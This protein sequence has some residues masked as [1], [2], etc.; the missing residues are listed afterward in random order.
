MDVEILI[1]AALVLFALFRKGGSK[2]IQV[3]LVDPTGKRIMV[4]VDSNNPP[5]GWNGI[6]VIP[7]DQLAKRGADGGPNIPQNVVAAARTT[8]MTDAQRE[9]AYNFKSQM[10]DFKTDPKGYIA[11]ICQNE[12]GAIDY[13]LGFKCMN[14]VPVK[15]WLV[16]PNGEIAFNPAANLTSLEI[17][18][19]N[20]IRSFQPKLT[21]NTMLLYTSSDIKLLPRSGI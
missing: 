9:V 6:N 1:P 21:M 10:P 15:I 20:R 16:G 11:Y 14:G 4:T 13:T 5:I 3:E 8:A 18:E 19:Y 7:M 17:A 12:P 2:P